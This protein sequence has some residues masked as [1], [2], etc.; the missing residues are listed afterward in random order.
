MIDKYTVVLGGGDEKEKEKKQKKEKKRGKEKENRLTDKRKDRSTRTPLVLPRPEPL[1]GRSPFKFPPV[2]HWWYYDNKAPFKD[3]KSAL[4]HAKESR[5][6]GGG[7]YSYLRSWTFC[8]GG[9]VSRGGVGWL[10]PKRTTTRLFIAFPNTTNIAWH[11]K[12]WIWR[13]FIWYAIA[14]VSGN[15]MNLRVADGLSRAKTS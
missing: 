7:D 4:E 5:M 12:R 2:R 11:T 8:T 6:G 15:V 9:V 13:F 10:D 1:S 14:V 3:G